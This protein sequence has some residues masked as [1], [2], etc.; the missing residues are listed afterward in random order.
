M[1]NILS[2]ARKGIIFILAMTW[3]ALQTPA[4]DA[5]SGKGDKQKKTRIVIVKD[6]DGKIVK[7]DT[8][9]MGDGVFSLD[10]H[11]FDFDFDMPDM[12]EFSGLHEFDFDGSN[13]FMFSIEDNEELSEGEK[14][15]LKDEMKKAHEQVKKAREERRKKQREEID[16]ELKKARKEMQEMD[17]KQLE[18]EME[19]L[20]EEL[21]ELRHRRKAMHHKAWKHKGGPGV[22]KVE[23]DED[24]RGKRC[25][26]IMNG[27]TVVCKG[28]AHC[29]G[30][31]KMKARCGDYGG[32]RVRV[33]KFRDGDDVKREVIIEKEGEGQPPAAPAA[34]AEPV[35]KAAPAAPATPADPDKLA[36]REVL[37]SSDDKLAMRNL[38]FFPNPSDGRFS[39]NFTLDT[40]GKATIRLVDFAG[41]ELL[42]EEASGFPGAYSRQ[43]DVSGS[44][45]GSYLLMISQA[46]KWVHE[47]LIVN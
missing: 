37:K 30:M 40:P 39:L 5:G 2:L 15:R 27:D 11:D 18:L 43:F 29:K 4:Q 34:P 41:R 45:R 8:T 36:R 14:A 24:G 16:R 6:E 44:A 19:K 20:R 46:D 42:H 31:S 21:L 32:K 28:M 23:V 35:E 33:M 9:I 26:V 1:E 25:L 22:Y 17:R 3:P 13:S 12:E 47:K 10:D 38:Q 7:M